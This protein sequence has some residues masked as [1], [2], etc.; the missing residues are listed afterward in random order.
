[1]ILVVVSVI[2]VISCALFLHWSLY[3][4][5]S[6]D[7]YVGVELHCVFLMLFDSPPPEVVQQYPVGSKVRALHDGE[8]C[9]AVV[10]KVDSFYR[11][12]PSPFYCLVVSFLY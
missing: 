9:D 8:R 10:V 11:E 5:F 12:T 6:L 4:L 7:A 1:M 3:P 2:S